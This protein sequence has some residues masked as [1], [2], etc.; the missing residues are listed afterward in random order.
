MMTNWLPVDVP[1]PLPPNASHQVGVGAFVVNE[2]RQVLVV[3]EKFGPLRGMGFWKFP[4]GELAG[5][6]GE[7]DMGSCRHRAWG[8]RIAC[9]LDRNIQMHA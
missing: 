9:A 7:Q 3:Q 8:L 5:G 4:T 2:K 1:S 6:G